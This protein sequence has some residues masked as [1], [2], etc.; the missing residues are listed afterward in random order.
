MIFDRK[1]PIKE[2]YDKFLEILS[3]ETKGL[4]K[5]I[6]FFLY[7]SKLRKDFVPGV[8]DLDGFFVFE[9]FF[10]TNKETLFE[11]SEI[12]YSSLKKSHKG[13][14]TQINVLDKATSLDGRFLT[15]PKNYVDY[16]KD[17]SLRFFGNYDLNEMNGFNYKNSELNSISH[18]LTKVRQGFLYYPTNYFLNKEIFLKNF[19]SP[20]KKLAQLP[21]QILILMG[22]GM[23]EEK[24]NSLEKFC[25]I[26]HEYDNDFIKQVDLLL[27]DSKKYNQLFNDKENS[28]EIYSQ[29]I[30]EIEKII[31]LYVKKFPKVN[32][33]EVKDFNQPIHFHQT[34]V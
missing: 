5:N 26:F 11:L 1:I 16:F 9:D 15:Y 18:N 33:R 17:H 2:D 14:K 23:I 21:K 34:K 8:S 25:E 32:S 6:S 4:D 27:G 3:E 19:K 20:I 7:G 10:V 29:S 22:E 13:I 28:F 31:K 30:T 12:L 24:D